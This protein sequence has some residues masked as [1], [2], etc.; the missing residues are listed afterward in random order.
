M[1]KNKELPGTYFK[2]STTSLMM[3]NIKKFVFE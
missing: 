1:K 2:K 3:E